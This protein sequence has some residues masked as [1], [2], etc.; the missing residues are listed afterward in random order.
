METMKKISLFALA[1]VIACNDGRESA[2]SRGLTGASDEVASQSADAP[3]SR[4]GAVG[5]VQTSAIMQESAA[6][7]PPPQSAPSRD[8]STNQPAG[9]IVGA[10]QV[11]PSMLI[12][13]GAASIE[14]DKLDP[15]IIKVRQMA[16][17][18]GGYVAN[19]SISGGR[20]QIRSATLELKIPAARYDQAVSG[21]G[22]LGKVESV[23][24]NVEDVGEEYVDINSR[25]TNAKR[26]EE[27][28]VSLLAT[29]TGRL[30]D[31]LAVERELAR[32]RQEIER[33]E[34]RMRFLRTRA[35]VSTLSI[36]VHEPAP[37]LGQS[38]GD[39]PIVGALKQ[40][41]RNFVGFVAW[42]IAS[43]GVLI[44]LGAVLAAAWYFYRRYRGRRPPKNP[45]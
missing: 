23:N 30:E 37:I 10:E 12:R 39:N 42:F 40:A 13:T 9:A 2:Q 18:L 24:T 14:V 7:P 38:P 22:G 27:R 4:Q 20:D 26:L 16:T 21:L 3:M 34:G 45:V 6:P 36:T 32:V 19:S 11:A 35:A 28:L 43:L 41:W 29:R 44:P 5:S 25:V 17:Q 8:A 15:A 31:V 1:A 33:Y